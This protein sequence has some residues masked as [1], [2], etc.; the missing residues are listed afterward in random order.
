MQLEKGSLTGKHTIILWLVSA[1]VFIGELLFVHS[2]GLA[3][4]FQL[5]FGLYLL[6][7]A[8]MLLLLRYPMP[9]YGSAAASIRSMANMTY[10]THPLLQLL[11]SVGGYYM[12]IRFPDAV[13][14]VVMVVVPSFA[15]WLCHRLLQKGLCRILRYFVG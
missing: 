6:L 14:F 7:I 10:Y 8:T 2:L 3:R 4:V 5:T 11:L 15:G 9:Q 1:L 12:G 13:M